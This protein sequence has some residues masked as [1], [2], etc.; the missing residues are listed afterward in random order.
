MSYI[1]THPVVRATT[2]MHYQKPP[3]SLSIRIYVTGQNPPCADDNFPAPPVNQVPW[4]HLAPPT[5][6]VDIARGKPSF[7]GVLESEMEEQV[8]AM[9][10]SVCG[11]GAMGDDV[12]E[13]VRGVQER[14]TVDLFEETFS[15]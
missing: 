8:G 4:T 13:A 11:P 10:V 7:T 15:W 5:V 1:L 14:K 3:L 2:L 12:R 6:P 9:A